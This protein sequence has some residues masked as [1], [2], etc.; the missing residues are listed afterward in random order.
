MAPYLT[1]VMAT[2]ANT[3]K[4]VQKSQPGTSGSNV[5]IILVKPFSCGWVSRSIIA[6]LSADLGNQSD[7]A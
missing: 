4:I 1:K 3:M 7:D 2:K 5:L 6:S